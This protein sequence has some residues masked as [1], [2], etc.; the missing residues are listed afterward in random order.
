MRECNCCFKSCRTLTK[1]FVNNSCSWKSCPACINKQIRYGQGNQFLY[2]CPLCRKE[3]EYHR[4]SRFSKYVK[5]NRGALKKILQLQSDY[6]KHIT[7]KLVQV[8]LLVSQDSI[9]I[10]TQPMLLENSSIDSITEDDP[11]YEF[12]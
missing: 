11:N 2:K 8:H 1:C 3:S 10:V 7:N 12:T 6:I 4:H 9:S 5:Q